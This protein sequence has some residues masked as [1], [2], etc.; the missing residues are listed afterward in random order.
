[1]NIEVFIDGASRGNPGESGAGVVIN[2]EDGRKREIINY[3]GQGTNNQ[4][5]Y[6]A[7][8]IALGSLKDK[9]NSEIVIYTDSQLVAN[10]INGLW[11]VKDLSL[12]TLFSKAR[13]QIEQFSNLTL[14][15]IKRE[16]NKEA[17]KRANDSIDVS[18][19]AS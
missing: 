5:E 12:K 16:H 14:K 19:L 6:K 7:L 2:Y 17:D 15:H 18:K 4:A 13:K 10:Q 11:K 1:M 8:L 3:L 9:K